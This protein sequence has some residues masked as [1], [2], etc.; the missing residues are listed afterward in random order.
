VSKKER[1]EYATIEEKVEELELLATEAQKALDEANAMAR[2]PSQSAI[3]ELAG[4][5]SVSRKAADEMMERY[6]YLDEMISKAD[7]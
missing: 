2:R 1:A 7:A 6:L 5:V 4:Q 3:L